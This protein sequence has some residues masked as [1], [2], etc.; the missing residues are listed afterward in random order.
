MKYLSALFLVLLLAPFAFT[1]SEIELIEK[2]PEGKEVLEGLFLEISMGGPDIDINRVRQRLRA[3]E[4]HAKNLAHYVKDSSKQE[5]QRCRADL[6]N[7]GGRAHDLATRSAAV[8]RSYE[9]SQ[10]KQKGRAT[11]LNRASEELSHLQ[12]FRQLIVTNG[13]AWSKF[14]KSAVTNM[15]KAVALLSQ[16]KAHVRALHRT[17]RKGALIEIPNTYTT[18]LN[19]ISAE[20][21][22]TYDNL[23][24]LRPVISNLLQILRDTTTQQIQLKTVRASLR[25]LL[26]KVQHHLRNT[27]LSFEQ[28]NEH[29][30]ALYS[31]LQTL[32]DDAIKSAT[33][34]LQRLGQSAENSEK[35]LSHFQRAV[36]FSSSLADQAR[37]VVT[38]M[39]KEC[40]RI[41]GT[42]KGL[43]NH[44]RTTLQYVD[45]VL[46]VVNDRWP[47]L[48]SFFQEKMNEIIK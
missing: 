28:E 36:E 32:Y 48:R 29:Q 12:A 19:E 17:A 9:H 39:K 38:L 1:Q 18:A 2:S 8:Q 5:K 22:N 30:T 45:Q 26:G 21:E 31:E 40:N 3:L 14:W 16:A 27:F 47:S 37:F 20:F 23:G 11:V 7:V 35:K 6:Q 33:R 42:N 43:R 34:R 41:L 44:V 10:R 24:G 13:N 25:T 46:E 4:T 15:R